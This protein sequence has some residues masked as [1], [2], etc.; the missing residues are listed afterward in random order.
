[1]GYRGQTPIPRTLFNPNSEMKLE[2]CV[3]H[4]L[5]PPVQLSKLVKTHQTWYPKPDKTGQNLS[6]NLPQPVSLPLPP[7]HP[8]PSPHAGA[9]SMDN[10]RPN[11]APAWLSDQAWAHL[12]ELDALGASFEGIAASFEEEGGEEE[13]RWAG[14]GV[15]MGEE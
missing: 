2:I 10:P 9:L 12:C 11:P 13:W 7:P 3:K 14:D 5:S 1:M 15:G 8:T 4:P 6:P